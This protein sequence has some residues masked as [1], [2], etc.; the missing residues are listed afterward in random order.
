MHCVAGVSGMRAY[1]PYRIALL[2]LFL[3]VCMVSGFTGAETLQWREGEW[4]MVAV[5]VKPGGGVQSEPFRNDMDGVVMV[6]AAAVGILHLRDTYASRLCLACWLCLSIPC[7]SL[8]LRLCL[9]IVLYLTL[10]LLSHCIN[11]PQ[12]ICLHHTP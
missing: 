1:V 5:V 10:I 12:S 3:L 11:H 2:V 4:G 6:L 9:I 7:N 8:D